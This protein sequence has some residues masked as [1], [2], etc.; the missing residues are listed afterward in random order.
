MTTGSSVNGVV[1]ATQW[2]A[3]GAVEDTLYVGG[4]Y[5]VEGWLSGVGSVGGL[6]VDD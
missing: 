6:D 5:S 2:G 3:F 1:A 4:R